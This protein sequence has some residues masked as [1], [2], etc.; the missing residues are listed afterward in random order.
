MKIDKKKFI[1]RV[2][3]SPIA[4]LTLG[5]LIA[6]VISIIISPITT[7]IYTAEQLGVYTL[8]ITVVTLFGPILSG[9]I[10]MSIVTEKEEKNIYP[11]I[12]LSI[13][14]CIGISIVTTIL[15]TVYIIITN[16][17]SSEY[18][19]YLI[20]ILFY[21]LITGFSNILISYNN[22][23]RDYEIISSVYVIR[24][25]MQNLGLVI[26]GFMHFSIVGMLL[27]QIIGSLFGLRRQ[28]EKLI[29][30]INKIKQVKKE[31][32]IKVA[33]ENY[34]LIVF[35]S[36]ATLCNSAS[37]S[38]LN[39]FINGLYGSTIFGYYSISYRILG[40]PLSL[41]SS[42]V[43]KVFFER[44]SKE[45]NEVGNFRN[46]LKR[47][48]FLLLLVAIPM[49]LALGTLAPILCKIVFGNE[50]KVS[51]EYVQ[52]L[53]FMFGVRLVVSALTPALVIAKKQSVEIRMQIAFLVVSI[54]TYIICKNF[55]LDIYIFLTIISILYS[56]VYILIYLF[57][58]RISKGKEVIKN[59]N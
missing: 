33:K 34:K 11:I 2:K 43:S 1:N 18:I 22:R 53:V 38:L 30:N 24:T 50:W 15:Y 42:N 35:T 44:A 58:Y 36:P 51:G 37:Y 55:N 27:S 21:L 45:I 41:V 32:I 49:V 17:F 40:V 26:F 10:E 5:S 4:K 48:T 52:I 8:L 3:K 25:I 9:K 31:E 59:E 29:P 56:I 12:V 20:I 54:F 39:F 14:I 6:Q 19:L 28:A 16:Q 7:R 23:N 57:I 13:F 46:S 47:I